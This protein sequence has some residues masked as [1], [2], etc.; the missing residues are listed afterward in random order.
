MITMLVKDT[1]MMAWGEQDDDDDDDADDKE[2]SY[3]N[4]AGEGYCD[5]GVVGARG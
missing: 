5:D 2:D 3:D 4:N 1:V